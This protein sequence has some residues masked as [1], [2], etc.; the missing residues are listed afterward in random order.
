M[1]HLILFVG[2]FI[3]LTS[4]PVSAGCIPMVLGPGPVLSFFHDLFTQ[5]RLLKFHGLQRLSD[6]ESYGL[7]GENRALFDSLM[8]DTLFE[9]TPRIEA[10]TR[11][12]TPS[13]PG[14]F[15]AEGIYVSNPFA[16]PRMLR[17]LKQILSK[18]I[19]SFTRTV[20]RPEGREEFHHSWIVAIRYEIRH[21]D[22]T[23][24]ELLATKT[25]VYQHYGLTLN[26]PTTF[27]AYASMGRWNTETYLFG[28]SMAVRQLK[29]PSHA[30]KWLGGEADALVIKGVAP[31]EAL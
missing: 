21:K 5:P 15:S 17:P 29:S 23:T 10:Q 3:T 2:L 20:G 26:H 27:F 19:V 4:H 11:N 24:S 22:G 8:R 16:D 9:T 12:G 1:K 7:T 18:R 25:G 30:A 28:E 13:K 6:F 31:L 14:V